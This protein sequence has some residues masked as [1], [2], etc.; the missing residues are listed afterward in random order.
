MDLNVTLTLARH[1]IRHLVGSLDLPGS[2]V[3]VFGLND[4]P[5]SVFMAPPTTKLLYIYMYLYVYGSRDNS[6]ADT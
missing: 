4:I 3:D 6:F 2:L 1:D 5:N